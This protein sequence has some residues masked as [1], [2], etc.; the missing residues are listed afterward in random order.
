MLVNFNRQFQII[1]TSIQLVLYVGLGV[2]ATYKILIAK[3][4]NAKFLCLFYL[5]VLLD[6]IAYSSMMVYQIVK[7]AL[8][9]D[10]YMIILVMINVFSMIIEAVIISLLSFYWKETEVMLRGS[11]LETLKS[12]SGIKNELKIKGSLIG[13]WFLIYSAFLIYT[14]ATD[15]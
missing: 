2:L 3:K 8:N 4:H 6:T 10:I 13:F 11:G 12:I 5:F 9:E 1:L 7:F 15:N 14:I